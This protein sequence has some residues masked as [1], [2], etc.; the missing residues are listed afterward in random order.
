METTEKNL[1]SEEI[2][3]S[4]VFGDKNGLA[5]MCRRT[6][7]IIKPTFYRVSLF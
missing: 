6:R 2:Q 1:I 7:Y 3:T 5:T 4:I